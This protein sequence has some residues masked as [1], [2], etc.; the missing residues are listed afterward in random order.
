MARL[1]KDAPL[2]LWEWFTATWMICSIVAILAI[3]PALGMVTLMNNPNSVKHSTDATLIAA[4]PYSQS[5]GK[6]SSEIR[7][8]GRFQLEDGRTIDQTIDG[9][10]YKSFVNGGEKPIKS[11]VSVSGSQLGKPDPSWVAWRD[12][13]FIS[14]FLGVGGFLMGILFVLM[15]PERDDR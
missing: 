14:F 3:V 12:G 9:F 5:T 4:H 8:Q 1:R 13:M 10:F 15:C 11:W 6:Y 2:V 7:W